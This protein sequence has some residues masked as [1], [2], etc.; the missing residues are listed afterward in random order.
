MDKHAKTLVMASMTGLLAGATALAGGASAQAHAQDDAQPQ[1]LVHCYGVNKC[2]GV[3][4]CGGK[5][6]SCAGT[7]AC[8]G[9]GY[10]D[11][12]KDACLK[13]Q[14]GRLTEA[15]EPQAS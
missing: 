4:A 13:I 12:P 5:G 14:D 8:K 7:N 9:Q 6:R 1:K 10:V 2:H 15:V 3:G 11:L